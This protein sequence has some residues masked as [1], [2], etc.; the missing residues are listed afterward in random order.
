MNLRIRFS[1]G[2]LIDYGDLVS[3]FADVRFSMKKLILSHNLVIVDPGFY[4]AI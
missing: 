3:L 2:D 4:D 1:F